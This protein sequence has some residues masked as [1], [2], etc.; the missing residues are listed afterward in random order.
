MKVNLLGILGS[1]VEAFKISWQGNCSIHHLCK[2][3][4]VFGTNYPKQ[5]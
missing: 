2:V 5:H 1:L 4:L 3:R